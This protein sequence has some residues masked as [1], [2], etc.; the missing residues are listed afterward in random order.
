MRLAREAFSLFIKPKGRYEAVTQML[1]K[2]QIGKART[3]SR[4]TTPISRQRFGKIRSTTEI[5]MR[6]IDV[7]NVILESVR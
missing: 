5:R 4:L 6:I 2:Q 3:Q 1:P 7:V